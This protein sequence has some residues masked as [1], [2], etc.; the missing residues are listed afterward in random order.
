[1][2][3]ECL[4]SAESEQA[5]KTILQFS[6]FLLF[7]LFD[8]RYRPRKPAKGHSASFPF[9]RL[10]TAREMPT[11]FLGSLFFLP[12]RARERER[13]PGNKVGETRRKQIPGNQLT[14][15]LGTITRHSKTNYIIKSHRKVIWGR[16]PLVVGN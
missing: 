7:S 9:R 14:R 8:I 2:R 11:S 13:D 1:M 15:K 3:K 12:P 16:L 5:M 6:L 10:E 4:W